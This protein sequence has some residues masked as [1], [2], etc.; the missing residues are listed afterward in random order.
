[1]ERSLNDPIGRIHSSAKAQLSGQHVRA[2]L[3]GLPKAGAAF[4]EEGQDYDGLATAG[5]R[6]LHLKR[7]Q[8]TPG[9][10]WADHAG[11]SMPCYC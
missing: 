3:R 10:P 8:G 11:L 7:T 5:K 9:L 4:P 6:V 1:M 2:H